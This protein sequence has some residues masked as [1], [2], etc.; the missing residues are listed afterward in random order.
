LR[1]IFTLLAILSQRHLLAQDDLVFDVAPIF[2]IK[3]KNNPLP[4]EV[5]ASKII[6][7]I[8]YDEVLAIQKTVIRCKV[9]LHFHLNSNTETASLEIRAGHPEISG[10]TFIRGFNAAQMLLPRS[11][12]LSLTRI[13]RA[14]SLVLEKLTW[15][16][17]PLTGD[18]AVVNAYVKKYNPE[19]DTLVVKIEELQYQEKNYDDFVKHIHLINDYF[20]CSA[21]LDSLQLLL[22][23]E[24][25]MGC[26]DLPVTF[27]RIQEIGKVL[28]LMQDRNFQ[29]QLSL[30]EFDPREYKLKFREMFRMSRTIAITFQQKLDTLTFIPHDPACDPAR[31]LVDHFCRYIR[32]AMLV[33]SR[34]GQ[35]YDAYI[36]SYFYNPVF[37]DDLGILKKLLAKMYPEEQEETVY[38]K[39]TDA[40]CNSFNS[41]ANEMIDH[42]M[43]AESARM[44]GIE[45]RFRKYAGCTSSSAEMETLRTRATNGIY[46]AY[47]AVSITSMDLNKYNLAEVYLEKAQQFR[48]QNP[49]FVT[50]DSLFRLVAERLIRL[51]FA[52]CDTL[53]ARSRYDE[54]ISCYQSMNISYDSLTNGVF[55]STVN[56]KSDYCFYRKFR[57][58]GLFYMTYGNLTDA[59]KF[60]NLSN[61]IRTR[62]NFASDTLLDSLATATYPYYLISLLRSREELIWTDRLKEADSFADSVEITASA[63]HVA[64]HEPFRLMLARYR[65]K[66][67]DKECYNAGDAFEILVLRGQRNLE[68]KNYLRGNMLYDSA[69]MVARA[70]PAC[71]LDTSSV[72]AAMKTYLAPADFQRQQKNI[73]N[74]VSIN[75]YEKAVDLFFASRDFYL[76]HQLNTYG[77][78]CPVVYDFISGRNLTGLTYECAVHCAG[79]SDFTLALQFL[80]LLRVQEFPKKESSEIQKQ[81]AKALARKDFSPGKDP[82]ALADSYVSVDKWFAAFRLAY[83]F[84]WNEMKHR[85]SSLPEKTE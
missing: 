1:I 29:E 56:L 8:A 27:L 37:E 74:L 12:T 28:K 31:L 59:G 22:E 54:A 61:Q 16:D 39:F 81:V 7:E 70:H 69:L 77:F 49:G 53:A 25:L 80:K 3:W 23:K 85:G 42:Y 62:Q 19:T 18:S 6:R 82:A 48:S 55:K 10:N 58:A 60:L 71:R 51:K 26:H 78:T 83:I 43:F 21:V 34:N 47:L 14:D 40:V 66:I 38:R 67:M 13:R 68:M 32:W 63:G 11:F 44:M 52:E 9:P 72:S 35:I 75:E 73:S 64:S 33:N 41:T 4:D 45:A 5:I 20:A 76:D 79:I 50:N 36:D 2:E 65:K 17:L 57:D 84:E 46:D 24:R 30:D 15:R